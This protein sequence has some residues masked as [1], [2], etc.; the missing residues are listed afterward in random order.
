M[1]TVGYGDIH[2]VNEQE[3][4]FGIFSMIFACGVF[5]YTVGSIGNFIQNHNYMK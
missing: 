4:L 2:P 5:A 1:T 3:K